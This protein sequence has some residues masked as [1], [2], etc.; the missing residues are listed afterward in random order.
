[1]KFKRRVG[2]LGIPVL[3]S[4]FGIQPILLITGTI[5]LLGVAGS[6]GGAVKTRDSSVR[7]LRVRRK[8]RTFGWLEKSMLVS[9]D[10]VIQLSLR[11]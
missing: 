4:A 6:D 11:Y 8:W 7:I 5:Y 9:S 2:L 10:K 1:M 3:I